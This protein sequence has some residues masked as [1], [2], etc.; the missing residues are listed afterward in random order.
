MTALIATGLMTSLLWQTALGLLIGGGLL[1]VVVLVFRR[2]DLPEPDRSSGPPA[3]RV[4][5]LRKTYG[6]PG[7]GPRDAPRP[8]GL[9]AARARAWWPRVRPGRCPRPAGADR[10]RRGSRGV[11]RAADAV[12]FLAADRVAGGVGAGLASGARRPPGAGKANAVGAVEPGGIEG[13]IAMLVPWATIGVLAWLRLPASGQLRD[14]RVIDYLVP[15]VAAVVLAL[16]QAIRRSARRQSNGELPGRVTRGALRHPRSLWRRLAARIGGFDLPSDPVLAL[17]GV[18]FSVE[19]GMVGVLGPNGAGKTTLLRQLAG[20]IDPTRGTIGLGGV[21][22]RASGGILRAGWGTCRRMRPARRHDASRVSVLLRGA[23]R[24][25]TRDSP[26]ARGEPARGSGA[27]R[28]D[29][30]ADQALSGGM[31][32]RVAVARTLLR[33]PPVIIVDEPTVGLDP[34]ERIRFRNL[35]SRLARDRIVLFSTHVVE[36]V[37]VACERVLV[38]ARGRLVFDGEP[39]ALADA[40]RG[41]VWEVRA[42]ADVEIDLPPGAIRA[43]ATPAADG[44]AVHRILADERPGDAARP[45]DAALEDGYLWLIHSTTAGVP[46]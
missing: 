20:V 44:S 25:A 13:W 32:Q 19:R 22:L 37:A 43:E 21:P 30:R 9:R 45:L 27:D 36:D 40:A 35:L 14:A 7:P 38:L 17:A 3:L 31:R 15:A 24:P 4:R 1:A 11:S 46:T 5:C 12:G 39:R 18:T 34:R 6:L 16:G 29:R 42:A 2:R 26:R 33:L 28:E 23:L 41:R 8:G 10:G